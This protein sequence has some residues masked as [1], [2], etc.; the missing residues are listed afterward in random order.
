[1]KKRGTGKE[2]SKQHCNNSD[3][4]FWKDEEFDAGA[5]V[6]AKVVEDAGEAYATSFE[7][8]QLVDQEVYSVG[9]VWYILE[10]VPHCSG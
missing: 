3:T 1:M 8:W 7:Q 2:G 6:A 9:F 5:R 4:E 10:K